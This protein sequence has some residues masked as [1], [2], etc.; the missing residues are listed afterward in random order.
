M[1]RR[2][3]VGSRPENRKKPEG[4]TCETIR[5]WCQKFGPRYA[6]KLRRRQGQ[7][8]DIWHLDEL[9]VNIQGKTHYLWRAV[10]QNG[11]VIYILVRKHRNARAAKRF[12][13]KL[14]KGR[15]AA[16]WRL[17]T[18]KVRSYSRRHIARSCLPQSTI[19][20]SMRTIGL[21]S[22]INRPGNENAKCG[23]I[24][25]LDRLSGSLRFTAWFRTCSG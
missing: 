8:G 7:L 5:Q 11:D 2:G 3:P 14:L 15:G 22:R 12:F 1:L 13:R 16:P 10:D 18:D 6:R 21:K 9:F 23:G 24:G 20:N 19:P 4:V 17:I 25:Q